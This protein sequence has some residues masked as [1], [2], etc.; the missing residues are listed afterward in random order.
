MNTL[1]AAPAAS[2]T[3]TPAKPVRRG[4]WRRRV[5]EPIIELLT[6]GV[7]PDKIAATLAVGVTIGLFPFIGTTTTLC[8]L[9]GLWQRMNLPILQAVNY[10]LTP[11]HLVM[12]LVYVR[13]GE[14]LCNAPEEKQF[15]VTGMVRAFKELTVGEFLRQ[16]GGAGLHA[17]IAWS[18]TAPLLFCAVYFGARVLLRRLSHLFPAASTTNRNPSP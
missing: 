9:I 17:L 14:W 11:L 5:L 8:L 10:L 4:I 1:H 16:F 12:I 6:Q 7:T 13:M 15:S 18:L 2:D 3:L